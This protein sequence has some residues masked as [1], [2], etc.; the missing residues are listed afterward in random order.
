MPAFAEP[1][2]NVSFAD[3]AKEKDENPTDKEGPGDPHEDTTKEKEAAGVGAPLPRPK[4]PLSAYNMYFRDQREFLLKTITVHGYKGRGHGK[5]GFKDLGKTI[6]ASWKNID[7]QEKEVY[8]KLALQERKNYLNRVEEWKETQLKNGHSIKRQNKRKKLKSTKDAAAPSP[9]PAVAPRQCEPITLENACSHSQNHSVFEPQVDQGVIRPL[10][11]VQ[12]SYNV[13]VLQDLQVPLKNAE[14]NG[15]CQTFPEAGYQPNMAQSTMAT[16]PGPGTSIP[17][18]QWNPVLSFPDTTT[19]NWTSTTMHG[20]PG[21]ARMVP[22]GMAG[23]LLWQD[24][25]FANNPLVLS[26][27]PIA[28][29]EDNA[30]LMES[31]AFDC[32]LE[33][34]L[35]PVPIHPLHEVTRNKESHHVKAFW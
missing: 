9:A 17:C 11:T 31:T 23:T 20:G 29:F 33:P 14:S 3:S 34:D 19:S 28:A 7:P 26:Q 24:N 25:T 12:S 21:N 2:V 15:Q 35:E 13:P 22:Q 30:E 18:P 10:A 8:E 27:H 6:A 5:I 4:R 16:I 32:E 1:F